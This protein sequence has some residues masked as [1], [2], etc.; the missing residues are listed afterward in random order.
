MPTAFSLLKRPIYLGVINL[1]G[2]GQTSKEPAVLLSRPIL[3][4][5]YIFENYFI[6]PLTKNGKLFT[7][8]N[9]PKFYI[10]SENLNKLH[11]LFIYVPTG[12]PFSSVFVSW[13]ALLSYW[14][15]R[16][17]QPSQ[18]LQ[19]VEVLSVF[20]TESEVSS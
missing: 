3:C 13:S 20:C 14:H 10:W 5:F 19:L 4:I 7:N 16:E 6:F 9:S 2:I 11:L 12:C 1:H 17:L 8:S 18:L 15:Q